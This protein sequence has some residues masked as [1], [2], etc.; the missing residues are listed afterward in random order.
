MVDRGVGVGMGEIKVR[1]GMNLS[2][3]GHGKPAGP[4]QRSEL[5]DRDFTT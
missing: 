1:K 2:A 3:F 5:P 4:A